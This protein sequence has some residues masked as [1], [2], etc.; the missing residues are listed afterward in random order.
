[1]AIASV[2]SHSWYAHDAALSITRGDI[3]TER[4]WAYVRCAPG[5]TDNYYMTLRLQVSDTTQ[6]TARVRVTHIENNCRIEYHKLLHVG[7][8]G[9]LRLQ[10]GVVHESLS[11]ISYCDPAEASQGVCG[12]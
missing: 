7:E 1:M 12:A 6:R 10:N 4:I 2:F 3:A 11:G 8:V 5:Q 9:Q